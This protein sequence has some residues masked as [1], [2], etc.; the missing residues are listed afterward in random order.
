MRTSR[1]TIKIAAAT[2]ALTALF[3]VAAPAVAALTAVSVQGVAVKG[4]TVSIT[5]R[6][7]ATVPKTGTISVQ[8][9]VGGTQVWS[10]VPV[11]L[12]AGQSMTVGVAFPGTVSAVTGVSV[13]TADSIFDDPVPF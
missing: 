5:V 1:I 13:L 7:N 2:M 11:A 8:A 12:A 10:F 9:V 4:N 3:A 6:N